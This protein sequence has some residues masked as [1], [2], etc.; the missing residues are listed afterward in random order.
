LN[1]IGKNKTIPIKDEGWGFSPGFFL[2]IR[3]KI[4][5]FKAKMRYLRGVSK[6]V[7]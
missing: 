3:V 5:I 7:S 4:K 6:V 1:L 2:I